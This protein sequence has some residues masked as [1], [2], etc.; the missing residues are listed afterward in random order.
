MKNRKGLRELGHRLGVRI[1]A[2]DEDMWTEGQQFPRQSLGLR[3][4]AGG[5]AEIYS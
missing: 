5:I 2:C 3:E 4:I 1:R